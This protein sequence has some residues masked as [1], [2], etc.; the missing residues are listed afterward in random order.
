MAI[1]GPLA[2]STA[3]HVQSICDALEI[4]HIETR[5]DFQL[6]R[7][8][9]SINLYPRPS[10]LTRAFNELIKAWSWKTFAIVYE[11]NEAVMRLQ[12]FYLEAQQRGWEVTLYQF[13]S[14]VPFRDIFWRIKQNNERNI[15]LDVKPQH[16]HRALKHVR[17]ISLHYFP[18]LNIF[19]LRTSCFA[20]CSSLYLRNG[21]DRT[22]SERTAITE[23]NFILNLSLI[24]QF[25]LFKKVLSSSPS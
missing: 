16:I 25:G 20:T 12:G 17:T 19:V 2:R 6:Q 4:P 15:V 23:K 5:W 13:K 24:P 3:M 22:Y 9:L 7:D 21:R 1:F 18:S 8:D 14:G 10:I 11:E